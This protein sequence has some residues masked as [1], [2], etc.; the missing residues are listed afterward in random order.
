MNNFRLRIKLLLL[1][2]LITNGLLWGGAHWLKPQAFTLID[3][4]MWGVLLGLSVLALIDSLLV[5]FYMKIITTHHDELEPRTLAT[6]RD[7]SVF[8]LRRLA[9]D[10]D[11]KMIVLVRQVETLEAQAAVFPLLA[12]SKSFL[13][14]VHSFQFEKAKRMLLQARLATEY[15]AAQ[16][17]RREGCQ[18]TKRVKLLSEAEALGLPANETSHLDSVALR[19]LVE[20]TK[21]SRELSAHAV[22]LG[23]SS[24]IEQHLREFR[25][26]EARVFLFRVEG[27]FERAKSYE[28]E[29]GLRELVAYGNLEGAEKFLRAKHE[30]V[31][32]ALLKK[33]LTSRVESLP[34]PYRSSAKKLFDAV[35]AQTPN[36]RE[37]HKA[38]H[39]LEKFLNQR[40]SAKQ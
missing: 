6:L 33:Q 2:S 38:V 24:F 13:K 36:S 19:D 32:T 16:V 9:V 28:C 8:H 15:A 5:N 18:E 35:C 34:H 1:V 17:R 31:E 37:F 4:I 29:G 10:A 23:C 40:K 25:Y 27:L 39:E 14:A 3:Y 22:T 12:A 11:Q 20:R 26:E 30:E 21:E 7:S